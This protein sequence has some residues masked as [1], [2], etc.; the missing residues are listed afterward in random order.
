V[1]DSKSM[2]SGGILSTRKNFYII[3]TQPHGWKVEREYKHLIAYRECMQKQFPGDIVTL[4]KMI[5]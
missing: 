2:P 1:I 5:Q 4:H 3:E